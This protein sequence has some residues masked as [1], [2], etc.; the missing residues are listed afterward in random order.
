MPWFLQRG[1]FSIPPSVMKSHGKLSPDGSLFSSPFYLVFLVLARRFPASFSPVP[2]SVIGV[3]L[4]HRELN[5]PRLLQSGGGGDEKVPRRNENAAFFLPRLQS[6]LSGDGRTCAV[7]EL[8]GQ[9]VVGV[10]GRNLSQAGGGN[11]AQR[12]GAERRWAHGGTSERLMPD[13]NYVTSAHTGI[14]SA[15]PRQVMSVVMATPLRASHCS[16]FLSLF[17]SITLSL[18][19]PLSPG[20]I[21]R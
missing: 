21:S 1:S 13:L 15:A 14:L 18:S 10:V 12:A 17:L 2:I 3:A 16:S 20:K 19:I 7:H 4:N 9:I 6:Q 5:M 11:Q 8:N